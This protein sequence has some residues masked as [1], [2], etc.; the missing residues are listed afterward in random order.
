MK[1]ASTASYGELA[2]FVRFGGR[3]DKQYPDIGPDD[4]VG[5]VVSEGVTSAV[6][7][8]TVASQVKA[9]PLN[10]NG[11]KQICLHVNGLNLRKIFNY[12]RIITLV[13]TVIYNN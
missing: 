4:V 9:A 10:P 5:Y 2:N 1:S 8:I 7:F 3:L 12:S 11:C 13:K 6:T